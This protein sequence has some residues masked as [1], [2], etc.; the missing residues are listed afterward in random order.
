MTYGCD[1]MLIYRKYIFDWSRV[2]PLTL[3]R[4]FLTLIT[5]FIFERHLI[6]VSCEVTAAGYWGML[7]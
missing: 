3:I 2:D 7:D 1:R 6:D 4:S 5:A